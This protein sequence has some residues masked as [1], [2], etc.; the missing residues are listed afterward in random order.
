M[1]PWLHRFAVT[2]RC[3]EPGTQW[4]N[5]HVECFHR[6]LRGELLDRELFTTLTEAPGLLGRW[7]WRD[8]HVR[9]H[10]ALGS[11]PPTPEAVLVEAG[12]GRLRRHRSPVATPA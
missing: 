10:V 7:R 5:G 6:R 12:S 11:R 3:I 1:R 8:N 4:E 2:T 9:P